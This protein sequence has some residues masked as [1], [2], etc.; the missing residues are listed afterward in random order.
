MKLSVSRIFE[1]ALPL[2][3]KQYGYAIF[4]LHCIEYGNTKFCN[5]SKCFY[6]LDVIYYL[7]HMVGAKY[8]YLFNTR[9]DQE[10]YSVVQ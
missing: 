4:V 9:A 6:L 8:K 5:I 7:L 3:N 10:I 2:L 1:K